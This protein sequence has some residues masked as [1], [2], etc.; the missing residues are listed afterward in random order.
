MR[1][2]LESGVVFK[3]KRIATVIFLLLINH[4]LFSLTPIAHWDAVPNQRISVGEVFNLGIVAFSKDGI[5]RVVFSI[6]GQGYTGE[7]EKISESMKYNQRTDVFEYWIPIDAEDFTGDGVFTVSADVYGNDGGVR[8]LQDISLVVNSSGGLYQPKAWVSINGNDDYGAIDNQDRKFKTISAAISAIQS[9]NNGKADG[10]IIYLEEGVYS[11]GNGFVNTINEWLTITKS[12]NGIK[13]NTIITNGG[14]ITDTALLKLKDICLKSNYGGN[15]F[16]SSEPNYLW[17]DG[18]IIEGAGRHVA[19]SN[20]AFR[21]NGN[22]YVTDSYFHDVDYGMH[23]GILGRNVTMEVIGNDPFVNVSCLINVVVNDV[24]PG[25]TYWH[26]DG[27]QAHTNPSE[28]RIIYGFY[29]K[30]LHY[31]GLFLRG[32]GVN[33]NNAFIN[34]FI[35][36]RE[37]G[38]P[39]YAGGGIILSNGD[40]YGKW[41]HL[42]MWHC[43]FLTRSFSVF[44][45]PGIG[46]SITNSSFI[47]NMFFEFRDFI[48]QTGGDPSYSL[49]GNSEN[50]DFLYNHYIWSCVDLG[51]CGPSMPHWYSKSP[52]SGAANTQSV[53]NPMINVSSPDSDIFGTPYKNSILIDRVNIQTV[54]GDVFGNARE[55]KPDIGA[56]EYRESSN[57]TTTMPS[58]IRLK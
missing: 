22:H 7:T 33:S 39:G 50:N 45:E 55:S 56:I 12:E 37:P 44:E 40:L 43:T 49:Y 21:G 8:S 53:G 30:N 11:L 26:A 46:F 27:F 9:V 3:K 6:N 20:P 13:N 23:E 52:D 10:G 16:L 28:N 34:V 5:D 14:T 57:E 19:Q 25:N 48:T 35:E 58:S 15:L 38:R 54:P 47:G 17:L 24:D 1:S 51:N 42:L 32:N 31:Q 41:D 29:G 18:C 36:M 4:V 2:Y